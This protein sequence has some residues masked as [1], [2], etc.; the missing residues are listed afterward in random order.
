ML[1]TISIVITVLVMLG[2]ALHMGNLYGQRLAE[3][4]RDD[5][6]RNMMILSAV[7]EACS[8]TVK[9]SRGQTL[10]MKEMLP[11]LKEGVM[12]RCPSG[13]QYA[14]V[15]VGQFPKC[16]RHGVLPISY[17]DSNGKDW[18]CHSQSSQV[19]DEH[20][21]TTSQP[22]GIVYA[23]VIF[24]KGD[25]AISKEGQASLTNLAHTLRTWVGSAAR[26]EGHAA[27]SEG[28][29]AERQMSLSEERANS[30][31]EFLRFKCGLSNILET[32]GYSDS[33][34]KVQRGTPDE[35]RNARVEAYVRAPV[36]ESRVV[37]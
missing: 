27:M 36:D 33:R 24:P 6:F 26:I 1:K 8:L 29:S 17:T 14:P 2:S 34:P 10:P 35:G 21:G 16:S 15:V 20:N 4:R 18:D 37:R 25:T 23:A 12:P 7:E 11:F 32:A 9:A 19:T 13:G 5:C 28:F 31:R 30:V 3:K 22:D